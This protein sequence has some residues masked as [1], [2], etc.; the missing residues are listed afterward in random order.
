MSNPIFRVHPAI[1]FARVGNSEEY[2][3]APETAAGDIQDASGLMGGLP[4]KAG[5]EHTV[6][7]ESDLRDGQQRLKRQAA[8]FRLYWYDQSSATYP[9]GGGREVTIG[10]V[11][12]GKTVKDIVWTVHVANKK[13]NNYAIASEFKKDGKTV[14]VEEGIKAYEDGGHPP[15]RNREE[16]GADLDTTERLSKL[17][18]D[19]GP[20]TIAAA[21]RDQPPVVPFSRQ[22]EPSYVDS[23][24]QVQ[25]VTDY[26]VSFPDDHGLPMFNP[27]GSIKTL[28]ELTLEKGSGRL[29]VLGGYGL[30]A[31]WDKNGQAPQLNDAI[32]NDNWFDDVSDGPVNATVVF[33][34]GSRVEAVGGWVITTDP[35]Y[36][37][38][39]RNVVSAWDD[40]FNTWVEQL[41]LVPPLFANGQYNPDY[42]PSFDDDILPI[43]HAAMLQQW[44][45]NLP[46]AAIQG[47]RFMGHIT[48][49]DDPQQKI[50][51]FK[52]LIRN[53]NDESEFEQGGK[54]MPLSLGDAMKSFLTVSK[55]QYF[56]LD[57][58]YNR[59][60]SQQT[61]AYGPG[62]HLDRAVL[63]NC[64]GGRYSPG[65]EVTFIVR[66][67]NLYRRDWQ[68]EI[69][70]FR[71]NQASL[72]YSEASRD[73]PFLGVGYIPLRQVA[74]QPGD[75]SK[76]MALP[77]HTDYNSCA[78]HTPDPNPAGNNTLY[79]SWPAQRPVAVYP[80]SQCSYDR[81]TGEWN[82][83]GQLYSVRGDEGQGT[84]TP[85]PQQQGRFQCYFD[86]VE[87]WQKVGFIIQGSRIPDG[88]GGNYGTDK[89]L[90]IASLFDSEGDSVPAWPTAFMPGYQPPKNCGPD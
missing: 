3:I 63:Q 8:R 65:I 11:I 70:P 88:N 75:L 68:G 28:G 59:R 38:Q 35:A 56:M 55:T 29:L 27:N 5:T 57:Q 23:Q 12:D 76:F 9:S 77:W 30:A 4:I 69:G 18:I 13:A 86:F 44:N 62:E 81:S 42:Q 53:P 25:Q 71:I 60:F 87:N 7:E 16:F 83:G 46:D 90:E 72:D 48:A 58:W 40:V 82:L 51:S 2:Y 31:G 19:P 15:A 1:N 43:L 49:S 21:D 26:P 34:D 50:P 79:W 33:E 85:Y 41:D 89:F 66:D 10:D 80:A 39:T 20:R 45:T 32:D 78:T 47:H 61:V 24:G 17:V 73:K 6:V 54:L 14:S 67:V 84:Q 74:V 52:N 36:A 64:L 37:P 22:S